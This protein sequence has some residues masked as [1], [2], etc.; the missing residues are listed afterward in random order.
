MKWKQDPLFIGI[1]EG[2][3]ERMMWLSYWDIGN[4][5]EPGDIL[6]VSASVGEAKTR[7]SIKEVGMRI[8]FLEESPNFDMEQ[9]PNPPHQNLLLVRV[10]PK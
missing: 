7:F 1:P 9:F 3:Q 4:S 5:L 8:I 10:F 6:E 2:D